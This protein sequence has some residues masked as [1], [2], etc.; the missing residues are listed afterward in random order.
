[1]VR[2]VTTNMANNSVIQ[3]LTVKDQPIGYN[4]TAPLPQ[5]VTHTS[6]RLYWE[7]PTTVLRGQGKDALPRT[8]RVTII[9]DDDRLPPPSIERGN[10]L[11]TIYESETA[12]PT[13]S[14]IKQKEKLKA[15]KEA[16][17]KPR[18][19]PQKVEPGHDDC[20][21]DLKGL[22]DVKAYSSDVPLDSDSDEE[23]LFLSIPAGTPADT[24]ADVFSIIPALCYGRNNE[25]DMLELCGGLGGI[26]ELA[27]KRGL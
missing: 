27:F 26:S 13:E 22:G 2:R 12:L 17:I 1:M 3:D 24:H 11:T 25:V 20:G 6:T 19:I 4:Y 5:G 23:E 18:K 10:A 9:E 16:G 7:A 8:R 15:E 14:R 21:E